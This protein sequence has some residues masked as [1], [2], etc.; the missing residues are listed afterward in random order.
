[1]IHFEDIGS[2]KSTKQITDNLDKL[3][4]DFHVFPLNG[5]ASGIL[6]L[7][8]MLTIKNEEKGEFLLLKLNWKRG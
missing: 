2:L 4:L 5:E 8:D 3:Q 1:M 7:D 6:Y